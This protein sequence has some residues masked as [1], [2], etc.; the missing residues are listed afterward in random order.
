MKNL[1]AEI[2]WLWKAYPRAPE[3][4]GLLM[5]LYYF[6]DEAITPAGH[7]LCALMLFG[8]LF[9]FV[10]G[11]T[12]LKVVEGA[13]LVWMIFALVF[14]RKPDNRILHVEIPMATEGELVQ[15]LAKFEKPLT[16]SSFVE[17]FRMDPS[18]ERLGNGLLKPRHRGVFTLSKMAFVELHPLGL[19]Q[20]LR[21]YDGMAELL[22][23]PK[24]KSLSRFPFLTEGASGAKFERLL[25]PENSR[26]MEFVG[27]REYRE[28]DSLRDL[29]Y[30]AFAR[31][32]KPFTKEFATE[33]GG[34]VTLLLDVSAKHFREK[35][36]VETAIRLFGSI[37]FYLLER[38]LLGRVWIGNEEV[39]FEDSK[40]PQK[41]ILAALARVPY[42]DLHTTYTLEKWNV[43]PDAD[44]PVLCVSVHPVTWPAVDK[45]VVVVNRQMNRAENDSL[46]YVLLG[47][48]TVE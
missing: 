32:G 46:R 12:V 19:S 34:G 36:C 10:P 29:H 14:R 20:S 9:L 48:E 21:P 35:M 38:N 28:G 45:Q 37:A 30:K 23:A 5:R 2:L 8:F 26:G 11:F 33:S 3:K 1:L 39:R 31:Y 25:R 18:V 27:V 24:I 40:S 6:W 42:A 17:S 43:L 47:T 13:S 4:P 15:I 44:V 22:V 41:K 7:V 16:K